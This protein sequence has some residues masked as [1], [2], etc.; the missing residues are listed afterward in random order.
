MFG[1]PENVPMTLIEQLKKLEFSQKKYGVAATAAL[2]VLFVGWKLFITKDLETL[3]ELKRTAAENAPKT[4]LVQETEALEQK[5]KRY[6]E[7]LS[8]TRQ[9]DWLIDQVNTYAA[10]SGLTLLSVVPQASREGEG[11]TARTLLALEAAGVYHQFGRFIE[12]LENHRP[13]IK[14]LSIK[15]FRQEDTAQG[16]KMTMTL[17]SFYSARKTA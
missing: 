14:I 2:V 1:Q 8:E 3:G 6:E 17:A 16:Q 11:G 10:D 5:L 9:P 13:L 4:A 15:I 12:K 7:F